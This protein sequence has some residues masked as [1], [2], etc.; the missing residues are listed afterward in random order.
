MADQQPEAEKL[1]YDLDTEYFQGRITNHTGRKAAT[2]LRRLHFIE[3]ELRAQVERLQ[4]QSEMRRVAL[5]DEMQKAKRLQAAGRVAAPALEDLVVAHTIT[6]HPPDTLGFGHPWRAHTQIPEP[7][8]EGFAG[9]C[10]EGDSPMAAALAAIA[11]G[12]TVGGI[13]ANGRVD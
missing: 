8:G 13:Q 5:L 2:E 3:V 4:A 10:G 1:A 9:A 12:L 7:D 11:S 6:L